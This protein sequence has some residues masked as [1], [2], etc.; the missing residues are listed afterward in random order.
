[1][2]TY[3]AEISPKE[4][5]G[6]IGS[7]IGPSFALGFLLAAASNIG[8][9]RFWLGWRVSFGIQ[10]V[11]GIVYVLGVNYLAHTPRYSEMVCDTMSPCSS[12]MLGGQ[13]SS[14]VM[15]TCLHVV[16]VQAV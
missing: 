6:R 4:L 14:S 9:T 8:F 13:C 15:H 3:I 12:G 5:R 2:P 10:G 7:F 16:S 11:F 1:M